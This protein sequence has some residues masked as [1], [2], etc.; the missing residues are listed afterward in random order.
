MRKKIILFILFPAVSI[1]LFAAETRVITEPDGTKVTIP[2]N[3]QRIACVY[4]P[5]YDKVVM[6]S[7]GSRITYLPMTLSPWAVKFYPE[8]KNGVKG[9]PGVVPDPE[10]LLSLNIDLVIYPKGRQN[11]EQSKQ[12]GIPM[13]CPFDVKY[14][15]KNIDDFTNEFEK[16]IYFLADVLGG[17]AKVKAD[18]YCKYL[19]DIT[20]SVKART[21]KIK[22]ADKPRV[23]Y[24]QAANIYATQGYN[25][26]MYWY[27]ELAGGIYLYKKNA[28]YFATVSREELIGWD[29][30]IIMTG[31]NGVSL[32]GK[33]SKPIALDKQLRAQKEGKV[34]NVPFG[35][36]YWE[37][38]SCETALLPLYLGKKFHPGLF[39]DWD[40]TSEMK[41]FYF[42][43]YGVKITDRDAQR[44]LDSLP[45]E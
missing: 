10:K 37:M 6:L 2:V 14:V 35:M 1:T 30:D 26:N 45:P 17:D 33:K 41:K 27:T 43:I 15:P 20:K 40:L 9:N 28:P 21:S 4:H 36:F 34:Y 11:K 3:P 18:R 39:A 32:A 38:T 16:Q 42:E 23:Y 31:M 25:T 12:T 22:Q 19:R 8:L 44:I 29:P 13:V 7:Q 24:G 5:A